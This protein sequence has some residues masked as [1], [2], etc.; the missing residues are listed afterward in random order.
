M[1]NPDHGMFDKPKTLN[2]IIAI[3]PLIAFG[4]MCR[5]IRPMSP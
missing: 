4:A 1:E 5:P 2:S 3:P